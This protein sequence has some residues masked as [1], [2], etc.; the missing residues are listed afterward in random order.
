M[1]VVNLPCL[2]YRQDY[3]S[4]GYEYDCE[5]E[6]AGEIF[7][8]ECICFSKHRGF[9]DPRMSWDDNCCNNKRKLK[10][11]AM[12][13]RIRHPKPNMVCSDS[14]LRVEPD[15]DGFFDFLLE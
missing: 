15:D 8:D 5:Y 14:R 4:G 11:L 3:G 7:C 2:G 6:F 1:S 10:G 13:R 9:F 12:S